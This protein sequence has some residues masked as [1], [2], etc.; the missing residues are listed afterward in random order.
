[1]EV[2][3]DEELLPVET[4]KAPVEVDTVVTSLIKNN[5]LVTPIGGGVRVEAQMA[6]ESSSLLPDEGAAVEKARRE[7][8]LDGLKPGQWW[9]D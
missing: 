3:G 5:R 4:L 9:W 8:N 2:L 6:L 1:M 7:T